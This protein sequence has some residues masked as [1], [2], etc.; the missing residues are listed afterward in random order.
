[1]QYILMDLDGTL[2]NPKLGITKS[3]QYALRSFGIETE[4][5]DT[6][7]RH[8]GPPIKTGFMEYSGGEKIQG[9]FYTIRN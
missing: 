1:M 9:V 3:V 4:D 8:I 2:T 6:L 7:T 5:L